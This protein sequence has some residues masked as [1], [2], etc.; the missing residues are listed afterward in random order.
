M[1]RVLTRT[2]L[3]LTRAVLLL[4]CCVLADERHPVTELPAA[5]EKQ[6]VGSCWPPVVL[7]SAT[8]ADANPTVLALATPSGCWLRW[9]S[10]WA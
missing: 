5:Q 8:L 9:C 4:L 1:P 7:L 6:A 3:A 10:S 2:R